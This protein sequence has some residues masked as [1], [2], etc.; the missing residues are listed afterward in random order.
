MN[1]LSNHGINHRLPDLE[2]LQNI[3][4]LKIAQIDSMDLEETIL[5]DV[6]YSVEETKPKDIPLSDY[7]F[8]PLEL[9]Q[10]KRNT[11]VTAF[12]P[13]SMLGLVQYERFR[14]LIQEDTYPVLRVMR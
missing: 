14:Y 12:E 11:I 13:Q 3:G 9:N 7:R 8:V 2:E 10:M 5:A 1:F 4:K 6:K